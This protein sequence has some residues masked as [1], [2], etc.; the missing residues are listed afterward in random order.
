MKQSAKNVMLLHSQAKVALYQKYLAKYLNILSRVDFIRKICIYDFMCGEGKYTNG[1]KGSAIVTFETIKNHYYSNNNSCPPISVWMN[2]NGMSDIDVGK[3]K[4][5]RVEELQHSIYKPAT[6]QVKFTKYEFIEMY[7]QVCFELNTM[8]ANTRAL[9]FIDPY[10]YK[11]VRPS[12]L[13]NLLGNQK[14]EI[15]FFVP[16]SFM[17]R[18]A[19]KS[20][21]DPTFSGGASL[22]K[23]L[24]ELGIFDND[25]FESVD[26]FIHQLK[27]KFRILFNQLTYVDTFTIKRDAQNTYALF[28]FTH[29]ETGFRKMLET[30]WEIDRNQG[31]GHRLDANPALFSDMEISGYKIELKEYIKSGKRTNHDVFKFGLNRGYLPKHTNQTLHDLET[32]GLKIIVTSQNGDRVRKSAYY[33]DDRKIS[34]VIEI[35]D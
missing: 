35:K 20:T 6:V 28:F 17:Y 18:F 31:K 10:G 34:V 33:L 13:A 19:E 32:E 1:E 8:P 23:F 24:E 21:S 26:V 30:K 14:T 4:I 11:D 5:E 12:H 16:I 22:K 3:S 7:E 2:D 29:N 27:N 9:I 25:K 15:I